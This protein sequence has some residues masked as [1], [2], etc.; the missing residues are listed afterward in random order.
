MNK[1]IDTPT[2][3]DAEMIASHELFSL[4]VAA[5]VAGE[6]LGRE[7]AKEIYWTTY[8]KEKVE[9]AAPKYANSILDENAN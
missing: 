5:F 8:P 4:L 6:K 2:I 9:D 3:R 1:D 7:N